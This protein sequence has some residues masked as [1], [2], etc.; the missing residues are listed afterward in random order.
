MKNK[1]LVSINDYSKEEILHI[2]KVANEFE[3]NKIQPLL[4]DKVIASLFFEP[5]TRTR[6]SFETAINRLGAR[7]IGFSDSSS[8]STTK[9]ETLKDTIKMVSN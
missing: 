8:S 3:D 6:L 7:V 9:G 5:S 4:R 2:L 1:S